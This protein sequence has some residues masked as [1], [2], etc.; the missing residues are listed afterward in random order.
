M[1]ACAPVRATE[2][3]PLMTPAREC[4]GC[5][6]FGPA[7]PPGWLTVSVRVVGGDETETRTRD[8]H[9]WG[10]FRDW[11]ERKLLNA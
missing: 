4:D 2:G 3:W 1:R 5:G 7:N 9:S 8:F 10:C 6:I 11:L